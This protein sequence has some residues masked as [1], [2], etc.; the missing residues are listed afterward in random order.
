MAWLA[1]NPTLPQAE[2]IATLAIK[3]GATSLPALPQVQAL[4]TQ[5]NA[6]RRVRPLG[7]R[8]HHAR[9]NGGCHQRQYQGQ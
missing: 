9:R 8:R 5:P 7:E 6:P 2:Q 4:Y 3:R 1:A